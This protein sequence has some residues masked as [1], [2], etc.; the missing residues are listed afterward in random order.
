MNKFMVFCRDFNI[1]AGTHKIEQS[2]TSI[3]LP[4]MPDLVEIFKKNSTNYKEMNV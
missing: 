1:I 4:R 3:V 2:E